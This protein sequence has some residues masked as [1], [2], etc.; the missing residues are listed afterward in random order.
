[1]MPPEILEKFFEYAKEKN[2]VIGENGG[3]EGTIFLKEIWS[4]GAILR[5]DKHG[6]E[7]LIFVSGNMGALYKWMDEEIT[8]K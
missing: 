8:N 3:A 7:H 2:L 6:V 4:G 5:N 1:M